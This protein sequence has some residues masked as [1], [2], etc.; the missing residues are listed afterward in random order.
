MKAILCKAYGPPESLVYEDIPIVPPQANE[1]QIDVQAA[2]VNFPDNLVILEKDQYKPKL[3]FSPGGELSGIVRAIGSEVEG[4]QIGDQVFSGTVWGA[5]REVVNVSA[6]NT[7]HMSPSMDFDHAA[8]FICAFGTAVHCLKDRARLEAGQTLAVLGAAGGVGTAIIQVG[9][10]MGARVIACASTPEKLAHCKAAGADELLNYSEEDLKTRLKELTDGQG[11]DVIVDPV[12]SDYSE[13][14]LRAIAWGGRF[15]VV[16]FTAG[17]IARI[18][19]NLVLLKGCELVG[20]FWSTST[21]RNTPRN[22][23]NIQQALEWFESGLLR[24]VIYHR[25]ALPEVAKALRMVSNRQ[26][27]GRL[28]ILPEHRMH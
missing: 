13:Q 17:A 15:A 1:I 3:P 16:G 19:L 26:A 28:L 20:V 21:R 25:F 7:F 24:P 23:R 6:H 2:G 5:F 11:V 4:F 9:K 18:P 14:A 10:A 8:T 12:G 22:R 27:Q